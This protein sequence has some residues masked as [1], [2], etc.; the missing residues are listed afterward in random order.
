MAAATDAAESGE[1]LE[2]LCREAEQL[3]FRLNEEKKKTKDAKCEYSSLYFVA[4]VVYSV[5]QKNIY[6]K[7]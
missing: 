7:L 2:S 4:E 1:T 3:K 6:V 5:S